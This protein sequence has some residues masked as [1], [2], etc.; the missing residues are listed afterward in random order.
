[1][2]AASVLSPLRFFA[3]LALS[4]ALSGCGGDGARLARLDQPSAN[5]IW[6]DPALKADALALAPPLFSKHCA[7]CHGADLKGAPGAHAPDLTDAHWLFGGEDIDTFTMKASDI[8]ATILHGIR[9][10]DPKTRQWPTMPARGTGHS[11]DPDEIAAVT[12][13]VLKLSGQPH[14]ARQLALGKE[15][16]EGEGGCYDCHTVQGWGDT[17]TGAADLTHPKTWLYDSDRA[18]ITASV[19]QGRANGSPAF[20]GK[21]SP[22]EAKVLAVYVLSKAASLHYN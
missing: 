13:Y 21:L 11:L 15:T 7:S 3:A 10:A 12:E 5:A 6:A 14:D 22:V 18:A 9:T 16:F 1:M 20:T 8:E 19:T 2:P 17:A 4:T